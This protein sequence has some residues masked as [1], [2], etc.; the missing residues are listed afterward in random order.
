[1]VLPTVPVAVD[2]FDA[3]VSAPDPDRATAPDA[4]L[5]FALCVEPPVPATVT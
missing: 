4:T 5:P 2:V 1:M 3:W